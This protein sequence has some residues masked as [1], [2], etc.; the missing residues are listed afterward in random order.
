MKAG[1][2]PAFFVPTFRLLFWPQITQISQIK[3]HFCGG[4]NGCSE[5]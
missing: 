5:Q 4:A 1:A 3:D 2:I